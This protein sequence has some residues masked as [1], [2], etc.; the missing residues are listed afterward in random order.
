MSK[1]THFVVSRWELFLR[2]G[3]IIVVVLLL[4]LTGKM[5]KHAFRKSGVVGGVGGASVRLRKGR[6][7]CSVYLKRRRRSSVYQNVED[8]VRREKRG[9]RASLS[10]PNSLVSLKMTSDFSF[11][12]RKHNESA[13]KSVNTKNIVYYLLNGKKVISCRKTMYNLSYCIGRL[14]ISL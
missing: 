10:W 4:L 2:N 11:I 6:S 3:G 7:V 13:K 8:V 1:I 9:R 5:L 14:S 12:K